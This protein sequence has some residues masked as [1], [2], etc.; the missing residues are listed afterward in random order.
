MFLA[1]VELAYFIMFTSKVMVLSHF[2][3]VYLVH[4]YLA[5]YGI[6]AYVCVCVCVH[7]CISTDIYVHVCII[8]MYTI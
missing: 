2:P 1:E 7:A 8:H 5:F 6:S 4:G 3:W